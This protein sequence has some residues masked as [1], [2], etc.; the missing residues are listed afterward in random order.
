MDDLPRKRSTDPQW[1][2]KIWTLD[3][4]DMAWVE[5]T[6]A[7][8]DFI[9]QVLELQGNERVL[10]LAC[11][12][13]RHALELAQRGCQVVGVDITPDYIDEA[14]TQAD[15]SGLEAEYICADL[16]E[17]HYQEAFDVVLN[18]ADG[19]IGYLENDEENSK[20]FD[21]IAAALVP[22][23]KHLM[24][25]CNG[26]YAA[27]HFPKRH[28]LAGARSLSLADFE[29]D[30]ERSLMYYGGLEFQY[31]EVLTKPEEI[32]S[33][34]TRLYNLAELDEIFRCRGMVLR[35]AYADFDASVPAT[36]DT[37]QIQ[38]VSQK[39]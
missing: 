6:Q 1:Y 33:N 5:E 36:D 21:V 32:H 35:Q 11:G 28:W 24:D 4:Q 22:G 27:R 9:Y 19:A 34:P 3:I 25:V 26:A 2:K 16:R 15:E 7:Q 23:G 12:F 29:W 10:D 20:I 30:V 17:L 31:G 13:G 8:V 37:L 38:V 14:R 18:M 39:Q